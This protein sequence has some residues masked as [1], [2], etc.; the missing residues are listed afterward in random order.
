VNITGSFE[1]QAVSPKSFAELAMEL[2]SAIKRL[3]F[4]NGGQLN[5]ASAPGAKCSCLRLISGRHLAP[6][7][8]YSSRSLESDKPTPVGELDKQTPLGELEIR[9]WNARSIEIALTDVDLHALSEVERGSRY[10]IRVVTLNVEAIPA[11]RWQRTV[12][13]VSLDVETWFKGH[14][15]A[16]TGDVSHRAGFGRVS[17]T[18]TSNGSQWA[19]KVDILVRGRGLFR[20]LAAIL[21]RMFRSRLQKSFDTGVKRVESDLARWLHSALQ[22]DPSTVAQ[23]LLAAWLCGQDTF[24]PRRDSVSVGDV[25]GPRGGGGGSG[26]R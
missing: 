7:S 9:Q 19:I 18:P 12:W 13:K 23:Q 21:L 25:L 16:L 24:S 15:G 10:G 1:T 6:G 3:A 17:V 4:D 8:R 2:E 26:M 11:S 14:H 22:E 5:L 20:P